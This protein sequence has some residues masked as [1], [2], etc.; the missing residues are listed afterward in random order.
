M[1]QLLCKV[2]IYFLFLAV[3]FALTNTPRA[4]ARWVERQSQQCQP[5]QV[6]RPVQRQQQEC[7]PEQVCQ[8][9]PQ[10]TRRC[11]YTRRC[12]TSP[13][14]RWCQPGCQ[15]NYRH[16]CCTDVPPRQVCGPRPVCQPETTY[17]Q[18]CSTIQRCFPRVVTTQ[19]CSTQQQCRTV[20]ERVWVED[21]QQPPP[22]QQRT[23]SEQ[24]TPAGQRPSSEQRPSF[25]QR[26]PSE[27]RP[28][29]Q[30]WTPSEQPTPPASNPSPGGQ[31]GAPPVQGWFQNAG[32]VFIDTYRRVETWP[33]ILWPAL[34]LVPAALLLFKYRPRGSTSDLSWFGVTVNGIPD[35]GR[36]S[37]ETHAKRP[38]VNVDLAVRAVAGPWRH[39]VERA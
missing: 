30:Q 28:P 19:E 39:S 3:G 23:P 1:F 2:C 35:P 16:S 9:V 12:Y 6:C 32:D 29:S 22:S 15:S 31:P 37:I 4:E 18:R 5:Q 20:M 11:H 13:A 34:L 21:L 10:V 25:E 27:Q 14:Y 24:W 17:T 38:A 7:R 36:Q 26:T 33:A 8:R